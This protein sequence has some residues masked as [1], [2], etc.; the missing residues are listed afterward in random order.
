MR[1]LALRL[2]A[3]DALCLVDIRVHNP[4]A[5]PRRAAVRTHAKVCASLVE[6]SKL[7]AMPDAASRSPIQSVQLNAD[8]ARSQK[9]GDGVH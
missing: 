2:D 3:T 5:R 4:L 1:W 8:A 9:A 7:L 6:T